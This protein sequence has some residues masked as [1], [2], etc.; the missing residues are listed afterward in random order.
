MSTVFE[1]II[2]IVTALILSALQSPSYKF[3]LYR[4]KH[5]NYERKT[6]VS[7]LTDITILSPRDIFL[8]DY[9]NQGPRTMKRRQ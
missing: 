7:F 5:F 4:G 8:L 2:F 6:D 1:T 9:L 3:S